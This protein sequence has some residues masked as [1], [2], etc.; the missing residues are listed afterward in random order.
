MGAL[1]ARNF[2]AL[3]KRQMDSFNVPLVHWGLPLLTLG[4]VLRVW[5][6]FS[7]LHIFSLSGASLSSSLHIRFCRNVKIYQ[8][9]FLFDCMQQPHWISLK[10]HHKIFLVYIMVSEKEKKF[11]LVVAEC[12]KQF[13]GTFLGMQDS[14]TRSI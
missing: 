11:R 7:I 14:F 9:L 13:C 1:P 12:V 2:W 6:F 5:D 4:I 3:A 10:L 8:F